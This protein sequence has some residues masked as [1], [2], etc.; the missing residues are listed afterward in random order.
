MRKYILGLI[1]I[2]A[3]AL[4]AVPAHAVTTTVCPIVSGGNAG[5]GGGVSGTYTTDSTGTNGGC[6]VLITYS[7]GGSIATTFPNAAISYDNGGDD[8]MVGIVNNSGAAITSIVITND[9]Q[10]PFGFDGDGACD[11]T[12][13]FSG[14]MPG[15]GAWASNPCGSTTT[16][17]TYG[18]NGITFSGIGNNSENGTINFPNGGIPNGGT[19]WFSLEGPVDINF[20]Q[21]LGAPEPGTL[22]MFGTGLIG[23]AGAIRRKVRL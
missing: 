5:G 11:P 10:Q 16:G 19:A 1:G 17:N 4:V 3:L 20:S 9:P 23:L 14:N 2:A 13:T 18:D 22:V 7:G 12:W 6:N 21:H 15:G 8:N